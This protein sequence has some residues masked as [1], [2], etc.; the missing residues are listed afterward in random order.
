VQ[1]QLCTRLKFRMFMTKREQPLEAWQQELEQFHNWN[2]KFKELF[3][4]KNS[5]GRLMYVFVRQMLRQFQLDG[6]Y[7]EA[8]I[9]NEAYLRGVK[10]IQEGKVIYNASA[11]L[12][13]AARNIVRELARN[14]QK[15]ASWDSDF[16]VQLEQ[17]PTEDWSEELAND[18][19]TLET[20]FQLLDPL[21]Q[22]ILNLKIVDELS[23]C[24]IQGILRIEGYGDFTEAVLRKKKERALTRLRKKYHALKSSIWEAETES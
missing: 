5:S 22:K 1:K 16:L 24:E 3:N 8:Y 15:L 14:R 11:W 12:K 4:S 6:S 19:I 18:T 2:E 17:K 20:A 7:S 21:E 13:S 9:L 10:R 23:W